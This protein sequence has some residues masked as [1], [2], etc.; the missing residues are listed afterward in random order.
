MSLKPT[1]IARAL[2]GV[3]LFTALFFTASAWACGAAGNNTHV[4]DLM[5]VDAQQHTFTIQDAQSHNAITFAANSEIIEGLKTASGSIMVNY[6]E[7]GDKLT[8][9][10][11]TF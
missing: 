9:V 3:F 11:V 10:G 8:A 1:L 7:N 6:E 2:T 4:G 5:H